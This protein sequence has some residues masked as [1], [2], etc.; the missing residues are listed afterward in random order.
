MGPLKTYYSEYVRQFLRHNDRPVGPY[1][2]AELFGK[3]YLQCQTALIAATG[4][5]VNGIYPCDRTVFKDLDFLPSASSQIE[6]SSDAN[7]SP[8]SNTLQSADIRDKHFQPS[9]IDL[10]DFGPSNQS[11]PCVSP[12][13][14]MPIPAPKRKTSNR[15]R[16]PSSAA[17]VTSSS[18]KSVLQKTLNKPK[19]TLSEGKRKNNNPNQNFAKENLTFKKNQNVTQ[20]L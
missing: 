20:Y 7:Q 18:Y 9:D 4:F 13:D 16:K 17:V 19:K 10:Q 2:I 15:G 14:I 11:V 3:A 5:K 8:T 6:P 1:D 12:R